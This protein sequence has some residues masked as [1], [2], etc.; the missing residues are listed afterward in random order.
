MKIFAHADQKKKTNREPG[1]LQLFVFWIYTHSLMK[2]FTSDKRSPV[3]QTSKQA[4]APGSSTF[5]HLLKSTT[6]YFPRGLGRGLISN[7]QDEPEHK[8]VQKSWTKA[9][10]LP[11]RMQR[12][13]CTHY[14][15]PPPL[16]PS[17]SES[18]KGIPFHFND[19]ARYWLLFCS[20]HGLTSWFCLYVC[21]W[22]AN[23]ENQILF[24]SIALLL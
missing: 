10:Q 3:K 24:F 9:A 11:F 1:G 18:V 2:H 22:E 15:T 6:S 14:L 16:R 23:I 13:P 5:W 20:R 17:I 7:P 8:H 12:V 21:F 19:L 4:A